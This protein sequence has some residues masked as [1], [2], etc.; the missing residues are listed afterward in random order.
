MNILIDGINTKNKGAELMLYG[1][2]Q[3]IE[4]QHPDAHVF[5]PLNRI[6]EGVSYLNTKLNCSIHKPSMAAMLFKKIKGEAVLRR[7]FHFHF[8]HTTDKYPVKGLDILFDA[9]GFSFSDQQKKRDYSLAQLNNY[10]KILKK[11]GVITVFLPQ[12]FGPFETKNGKEQAAL[13]KEYANCIIARDEVSYTHLLNTGIDRN[14]IL[15]YP[16]FTA[17]V[18]G[19]FPANSEHLENGIAIIP[20]LRMIDRGV[21]AKDDYIDLLI[22]VISTCKTTKRPVF[23]LNHEGMDD[24]KLCEEIN[25][26]LDEKLIIVSNLT[27]LE[28]KGLISRCYFVFSS[29]FH[30]LVSSL[31]TGVPCMA[32]GWSHKYQFLFKDYGINDCVF[33][34]NNKSSFYQKL[35]QVLNFD[36]NTTLR[37]DLII[38]ANNIKEKNR[39]MWRQIWMIYNH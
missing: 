6:P 15:Q 17:L 4:R 33:D 21:I 14:K 35:E 32:T 36:Y 28:I 3:E 22:K 16:D 9:S 19:I 18:E 5:L 34:P 8:L 39:E 2:L 27:S 26:K 37:N 10:Y 25:E 11:R 23:F 7:L 13:L 24:V 29:R 31:S 30:G 20:N 1:V 12:A 38:N